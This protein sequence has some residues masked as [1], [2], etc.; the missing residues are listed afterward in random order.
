M[1]LTVIIAFWHSHSRCRKNCIIHMYF[2]IL[3]LLLNLDKIVSASIC[4]FAASRYLPEQSEETFA[5]VESFKRFCA[6]CVELSYS[7]YYIPS[8]EHLCLYYT[9]LTRLLIH[10][11]QGMH[12]WSSKFISKIFKLRKVWTFKYYKSNAIVVECTEKKPEFVQVRSARLLGYT[13]LL[14]FHSVSIAF[15]GT[16][17]RLWWLISKDQILFSTYMLVF[18]ETCSFM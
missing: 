17:A 8:E 15:Q 12:A 18:M 10:L 4:A 7:F 16:T 1:H 6:L 5:F 3:Y 9:S 2:K 11:L 14:D 13:F